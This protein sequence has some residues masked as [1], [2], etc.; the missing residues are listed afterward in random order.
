VFNFHSAGLQ[1]DPLVGL[2]LNNLY[3][4]LPLKLE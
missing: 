4:Q 1:T 2:L 3:R